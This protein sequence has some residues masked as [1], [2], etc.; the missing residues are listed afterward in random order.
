MQLK[1]PTES[2]TAPTTTSMSTT[3]TS[4]ASADTPRPTTLDTHGGLIVF[5]PAPSALISSVSNANSPQSLECGESRADPWLNH[6]LPHGYLP[7][8]SASVPWL[9][10][11]F[12]TETSSSLQSHSDRSDPLLLFNADSV[13]K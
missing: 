6:L 2:V 11:H 8:P 10:R 9:A 5:H 12:S 1:R 13:I 7:L 4:F 3:G